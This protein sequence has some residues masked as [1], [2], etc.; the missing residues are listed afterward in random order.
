MATLSRGVEDAEVR[1]YV[2]EGIAIANE[3]NNLV[4]V[5]DLCDLQG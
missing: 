1:V 5:K 3:A 4:K 2:R